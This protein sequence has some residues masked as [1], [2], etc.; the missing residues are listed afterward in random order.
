[1]TDPLG[2]PSCWGAST[3]AADSEVTVELRM[4]RATAD[5]ARARR[6]ARSG[7]A[8]AAFPAFAGGPSE[9][10]KGVARASPC[11]FSN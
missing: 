8:Q 4:S 5:A 11:I 1:M 9:S 3:S 2:R 7:D 6:R 10:V